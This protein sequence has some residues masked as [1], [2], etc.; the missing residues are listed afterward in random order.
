MFDSVPA[1]S[2]ALQDLVNKPKNTEMAGCEANGYG[3]TLGVVSL[4]IHKHFI[5]E[6]LGFRDIRLNG[7]NRSGDLGFGSAHQ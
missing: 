1:M 2:L 4:K 6:G 3:N 7:Y 5:L